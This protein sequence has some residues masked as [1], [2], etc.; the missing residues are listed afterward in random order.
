MDQTINVEGRSLKLSNLDKEMYPDA[1]FTKAHVIDYYTR[2]AP[3]LLPHL[4]GRPLTV[5]RW[6]N[7]VGQPSFYAKNAPSHTPQWIRTVRL[8]APGSTKNRE[9]IDYLIIDDLPA[10]VWLANLASLE[11]HVPQWTVDDN[12]NP[13]G[14]DRLVFDLDPGEPAGITECRETALLLREK[15][16]ADGLTPYIKTSGSKGLQLYVS[17]PETARGETSAYA[18]ELAQQLEKDHPRLILSNMTRSL[19]RGKVLVDWSQNNPHKTTVCPYSLRAKAQ[20][21]VS[22]P[23]SWDEVES[24]ADLSFTAP[25]VL[26]RVGNDG[27]L[28]AGL[29]HPG[30]P[31]P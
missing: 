20:P 24:D 21:T 15:L 14:V 4:A 8:P 12:G 29:T 27:D 26:A 28:F 22:A 16:T 18:R 10:V 25:D 30:P 9:E 5:R 2:I 6:P 3:V 31:L 13:Q 19:R 11:L 7:G 1:G 23:I 17:L